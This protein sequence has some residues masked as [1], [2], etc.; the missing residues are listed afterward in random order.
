MTELAQRPA[1]AGGP[2]ALSPADVIAAVASLYELVNSYAE[3]NDAEGTVA[4]PVIQ[5]LYAAGAM[6][7]V[8]PCELG[9]SEMTPRQAMD[10]Y[11]TLSYADPSTG[12]VVMALAMSTGL[13]GAFFEEAAAAELFSTPRLG[14]AGQGTRAGRAEP[15][16][17]GYRVSGQWSFASGIRHATHLH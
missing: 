14:I 9:G 13:A 8:T 3:W 17:G 1:P 11:R 16:E 6:G 10:V 2:A 4:E 15:T 12:W 7:V 5:A